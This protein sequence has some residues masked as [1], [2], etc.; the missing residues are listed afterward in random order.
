MHSSLD[1]HLYEIN[2]NNTIDVITWLPKNKEF[3]HNVNYSSLFNEL[4]CKLSLFWHEWANLHTNKLNT[5]FFCSTSPLKGLNRLKSL[6][7]A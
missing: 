4:V 3:L 7:L 5:T 1:E 6:K 2:Y